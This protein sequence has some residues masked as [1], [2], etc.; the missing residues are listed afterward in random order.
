MLTREVRCLR[1]SLAFLQDRYDWLFY[2]ELGTKP[3]AKDEYRVYKNLKDAFARSVRLAGLL[4]HHTP[5]SLRH[6]CG[7]G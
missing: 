2:P 5:N 6:T 4:S 7:S 3:T 1:S